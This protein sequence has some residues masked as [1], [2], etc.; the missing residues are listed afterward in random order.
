ME[1]KD[2]IMKRTVKIRIQQRLCVLAKSKKQ[3]E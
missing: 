2:G 1:T 3:I